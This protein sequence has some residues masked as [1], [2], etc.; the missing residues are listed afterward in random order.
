MK[1]W[2]MAFIVFA[3]NAVQP[4]LADTIFVRG[5]FGSNT[6]HQVKFITHSRTPV[7]ALLNVQ[8]GQWQGG[9]CQV[10]A[11]KD[12]G[13]FSVNDGEVIAVDSLKVKWGLG[14]GYTCTNNIY[15]YHGK[16]I[17]DSYQVKWNGSDYTGSI[18]FMTLVD[19]S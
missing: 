6:I 12:L 7:S 9:T 5:L 16:S 11:S 14:G 1:K 18:P 8:V 3:I 2:F 19:L 13:S 10:Q 4:V 17:V 15:N